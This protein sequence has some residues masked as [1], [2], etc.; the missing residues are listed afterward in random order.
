MTDKHVYD[1]EEQKLAV[2]TVERLIDNQLIHMPEDHRAEYLK[3]I[4]D[5]IL[6]KELES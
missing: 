4:K 5:I 1:A 3:S 6:A 2:D